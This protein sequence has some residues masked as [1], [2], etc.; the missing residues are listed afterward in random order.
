MLSQEL[1]GFLIDENTGECK[2][3]ETK[4]GQKFNANWVVAGIDY[5][6]KNWVSPS[7]IDF[8]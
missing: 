2:G 7:I 1:T 8:E 5:L 3:V 6:D 4:D